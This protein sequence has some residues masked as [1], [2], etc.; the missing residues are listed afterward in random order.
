LALA[1]LVKRGTTAVQAAG[2][3]VQ[4][5]S[6]LLMLDQAYLSPWS[7]FHKLTKSPIIIVQPL[8]HG[9][10]PQQAQGMV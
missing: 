6:S 7:D 9:K 8:T 1:T 3:L 2:P 4:E 10:V 5:A